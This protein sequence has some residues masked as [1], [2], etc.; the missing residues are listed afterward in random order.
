MAVRPQLSRSP[1][2]PR[3][4]RRSSQQ[5]VSLVAGRVMIIDHTLAPPL[6]PLRRSDSSSSAI[7]TAQSTRAPSP[8]TEEQSFLGEKQI[9]DFAL[10]SEIGRGAY[11]LVKRGREILK[12]GTL[13]V[14][15]APPVL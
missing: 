7:S 11:G 15:I 6:Q 3:P 14:R 10:E 4:R 5:R 9:T 8:S 2:S 1:S 12:D 13:G